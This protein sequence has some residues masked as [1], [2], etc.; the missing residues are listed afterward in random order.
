MVSPATEKSV[1]P[2][3]PALACGAFF[4]AHSD[5]YPLMASLP[6]DGFAASAALPEHLSTQ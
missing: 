6:F 5:S 2:E 1:T 4:L 3:G